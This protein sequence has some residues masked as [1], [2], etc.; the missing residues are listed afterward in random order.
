MLLYGCVSL[1]VF[2]RDRDLRV[3]STTKSNA[4]VLHKRPAFER[5]DPKIF[6]RAE[7]IV[8]ERFTRLRA[9]LVQIT[10]QPQSET[11][12]VETKH[13]HTKKEN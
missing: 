5:L 13:T 10:V 3:R 7:R 2:V 9:A 1:Y 12:T 11:P 8:A 6:V 4:P